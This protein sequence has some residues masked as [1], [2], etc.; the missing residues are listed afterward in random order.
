[1]NK[2]LGKENT[3]TWEIDNK[4]SNIVNTNSTNDTTDVNTGIETDNTNLENIEWEKL[5][6][7]NKWKN[8]KEPS[9]ET[10]TTWTSSKSEEVIIKDFEKELDSL[11]DIIDENAK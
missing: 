7:D 2:I 10:N 1:L 3:Q 8:E 4:D 11:F 9:T 6:N 5:L